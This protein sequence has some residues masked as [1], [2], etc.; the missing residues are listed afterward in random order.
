MS[1]FAK[2]NTGGIKFRD[3]TAQCTFSWR[4]APTQITAGTFPDSFIDGN[5]ETKLE[6]YDNWTGAGN[7]TALDITFPKV[8][9]FLVIDDIGVGAQIGG[10]G[11][12]QR[13]VKVDLSISADRAPNSVVTYKKTVIDAHFSERF[14]S[15]YFGFIQG[16]GDICRITA[17]SNTAGDYAF[18][19]YNL[20]VL[21]IVGV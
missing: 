10:D 13:V 2:W 1:N 19:I 9:A 11:S 12:A 14:R 20:R 18:E 17:Y 16:Y 15:A 3:I 5:P 21:E 7:K 8:G 6:F 4:T